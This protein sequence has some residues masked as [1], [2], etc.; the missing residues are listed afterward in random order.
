MNKQQKAALSNRTVTQGQPLLASGKLDQGCD[1][2]E[3]TS[4]PPLSWT[5]LF[6]LKERV[7]AALQW[8]GPPILARGAETLLWWGEL[9]PLTSA[10]EGPPGS[11]YVLRALGSGSQGGVNQ[12]RQIKGTKGHREG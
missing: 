6:S 2:S 10:A 8:Q 11:S 3:R 5:L 4:F 1:S 9:S 7:L 12:G